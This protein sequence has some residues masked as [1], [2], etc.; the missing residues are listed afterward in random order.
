M[1]QVRAEISLSQNLYNSALMTSSLQ[2]PRV[3]PPDPRKRWTT[4]E[5]LIRTQGS[6][7]FLFNSTDNITVNI[8][9]LLPDPRA[10]SLPVRHA[11]KNKTTV[12]SFPGPCDPLYFRGGVQILI[13]SLVLHFSLFLTIWRLE[14]FFFFFF[15]SASWERR[16]TGYLFLFSSSFSLLL[17]V[18]FLDRMCC[19]FLIESYPSFDFSSP[20]RTRR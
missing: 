17:I 9:Q 4:E 15:L 6:P 19:C 8:L 5:H 12:T 13:S 2:P 14:S 3:P 16:E 1:Q 10:L 11:I 18:L 20:T 7:I